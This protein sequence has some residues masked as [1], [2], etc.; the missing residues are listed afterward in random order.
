M[1]NRISHFEIMGGEGSKLQDF[2]RD[3]FQW[4][5]KADN[6]MNYGMV[7]TGGASDVGGGI[8]ASM[9]GKPYVTV[10]IEVDDP[11]AAHEKVKQLG[12]QVVMEP[13]EV[14]GGP[15]IAQ[16]KDPAGNLVGLVKANSM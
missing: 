4:S 10:Y 6:P 5:V 11:A 12:G 7:A 16:F 13:A 9:D 2:Y 8:G 1:P 14:P 15:T 3:A